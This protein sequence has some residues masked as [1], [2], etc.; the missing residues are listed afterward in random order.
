MDP[1][2][3][4]DNS[5]FDFN[6]K[7]TRRTAYEL[8]A[9]HFVDKQDDVLFLGPRGTGKSDLARAIGRCAMQQGHRAST[10]KRTRSSR[11]SRLR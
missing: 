11:S 8:A 3:T 5:D 2:R 10:A 1:D 6:K 4:L 9:G 7:T